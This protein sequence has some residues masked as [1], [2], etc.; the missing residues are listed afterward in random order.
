MKE[1]VWFVGYCYADSKD[2]IS[3]KYGH[4]CTLSVD[5]FGKFQS[6]TRWRMRIE[7]NSENSGAYLE[8]NGI[9]TW[10]NFYIDTRRCVA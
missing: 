9:E 3:F 10:P 2:G 7:G 1:P 8:N 5:F 6:L 4:N